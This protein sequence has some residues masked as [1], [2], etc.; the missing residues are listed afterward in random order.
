MK[1]LWDSVDQATSTWTWD[2]EG[3]KRVGLLTLHLEKRNEGTKWSHVFSREGT[4]QGDVEVPE[5]V[6][7]SEM[8]KI[9]EALEKYTSELKS[10]DDAGMGTGVPSLATGEIDPAVDSEVGKRLTVS[11]F[12]A[13]T[14]EDIAPS[15]A[16]QEV[17]AYPLPHAHPVDGQMMRSTR[18]LT[19]KNGIDGPLFEGPVMPAVESWEHVS[20]FPALAFV[21][22]SKRDTRF[23]FHLGREAVVA[24]ENGGRDAGPNMYIYHDAQGKSQSKQG[25]VKLGGDGRSGSLLGVAGF[26]R[27]GKIVLVCVRE[28]ELVIVHDFL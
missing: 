15:T 11:Y 18:S 4:G 2:K 10:G 17:L 9:R 3:E 23:V 8:W 27:D 16:Y 1:E 7:P 6:D 25:I 24:M 26:K 19:I 21:L 20:T 14:G 28:K 22:A 5:T 13:L 12:D